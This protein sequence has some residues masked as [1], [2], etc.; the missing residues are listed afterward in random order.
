MEQVVPSDENASADPTAFADDLAV[1]DVAATLA[2]CPGAEQ[3][4]DQDMTLQLQ[5]SLQARDQGKSSK[6]NAKPKV[7]TKKPSASNAQLQSSPGK[8]GTKSNRKGP[9]KRP[10]AS[11]SSNNKS[12]KNVVNSQ[13]VKGNK[14]NQ[15]KQKSKVITKKNSDPKKSAAVK[16]KI[17]KKQKMT[18]ECVYSRAYHSAVRC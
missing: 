12:T 13:E 17:E 10:A 1:A 2:L 7:V 18:R 9:L 14:R 3:Q 11:K 8:A 16:K 4:S 5:D 6:L 15:S